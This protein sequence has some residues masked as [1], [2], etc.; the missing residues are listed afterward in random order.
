[1]WINNLKEK[2]AYISL[3]KKPK[4]EKKK[5]KRCKLWEKSKNNRE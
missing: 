4:D 2:S 5:I 1:M 3:D